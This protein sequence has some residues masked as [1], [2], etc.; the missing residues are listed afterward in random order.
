MSMAHSI[1]EAHRRCNG[2][3]AMAAALLRRGFSKR[4]VYAAMK[5]AQVEYGPKAADLAEETEPGWGAFGM[6]QDD[7]EEL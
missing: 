5:A 3:R 7:P 1:P 6:A 4:T 2:P